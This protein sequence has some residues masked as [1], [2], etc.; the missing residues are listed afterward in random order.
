MNA[1]DAEKITG[2]AILSFIAL[3]TLI[4]YFFVKNALSVIRVSEIS[5]GELTSPTK[6]MKVFAKEVVEKM[7]ELD[8]E[9]MKTE[10]ALHDFL[11]TSIVRDLKKK[12]VCRI[13]QM[14]FCIC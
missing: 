11:P 3:V 8:Q 10:T 2:I 13:Y 4:F 9:K 12:K 7:R 6:P 14:L 5:I 1:A